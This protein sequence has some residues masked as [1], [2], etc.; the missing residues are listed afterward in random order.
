MESEGA[1]KLDGQNEEGSSCFSP[2]AFMRNGGNGV[3]MKEDTL[4]HTESA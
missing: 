4:A 3:A 2:S 1:G